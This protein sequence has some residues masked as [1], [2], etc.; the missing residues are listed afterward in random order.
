VERS[1]SKQAGKACGGPC[2]ECLV[3]HD[4]EVNSIL[5]TKEHP[6]RSLSRR[7]TY[8]ARSFVF[9]EQ[10]EED[11]REENREERPLGN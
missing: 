3:G 9:W 11:D 1:S 5:Y 7:L 6:Q 10:T 8:M 4:K 2:G